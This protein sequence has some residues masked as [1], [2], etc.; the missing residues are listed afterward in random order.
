MFSEQGFFPIQSIVAF[1]VAES[2]ERYVGVV[3]VSF[4]GKENRIIFPNAVPTVP[5]FV[6]VAEDIVCSDRKIGDVLPGFVG[7]DEGL[8]FCF[9]GMEGAS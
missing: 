8:R 9:G 6:A 7:L 5:F 1:C 2:Q 3:P 4:F